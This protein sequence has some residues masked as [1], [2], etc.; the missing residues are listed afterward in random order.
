[1]KTAGFSLIEVLVATAIVT[2]GVASLS[3]LFVLSARANRIANTASMTVLL[4]EEK[5]EQLRADTTGL[6]PSPPDALSANREGYFD[7]LDPSG[8]PL[9][10]GTS[11][12]LP[13]GVVYIRRWSVEPLET[14]S[15]SAG[16]AIVLQVLVI[17]WGG[18]GWAEAGGSMARVP[19]GTRLVSLRPRTAG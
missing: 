17:P 5:M 18:R 6:V 12:T 11:T 14:V 9:G 13:S 16:S 10:D 19:G 8:R 7:G 3:Q 15:T 1:M 4:A 2:V